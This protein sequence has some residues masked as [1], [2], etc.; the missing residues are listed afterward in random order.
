MIVVLLE[1]VLA[2]CKP[3]SQWKVILAPEDGSMAVGPHWLQNFM[4]RN[5]LAWVLHLH[6]KEEGVLGIWR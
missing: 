4:V 6:L 2:P 5:L 1:L 3:A